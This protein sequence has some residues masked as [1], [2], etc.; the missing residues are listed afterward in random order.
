MTEDKGSPLSSAILIVCFQNYLP[1]FS[2]AKIGDFLGEASSGEDHNIYVPYEARPERI[3]ETEELEEKEM[4][5]FPR[6]ESR[7]AVDIERVMI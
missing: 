1:G 5:A 3:N 2:G 6:Y 4:K 7:L